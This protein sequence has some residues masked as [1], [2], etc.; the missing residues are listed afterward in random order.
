MISSYS[1]VHQ[2]G[3]ISKSAFYGNGAGVR[4]YLVVPGACPV[5]VRALVAGVDVDENSRVPV[6]VRR[7]LAVTTSAVAG[8]R[9]GLAC[10]CAP[11]KRRGFQR[12]IRGGADGLAGGGNLESGEEEGNNDGEGEHGEDLD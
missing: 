12:H 9:D 8:E 2:S 6:E 10:E 3:R 4:G 7:T 1:A 11:V 5:G